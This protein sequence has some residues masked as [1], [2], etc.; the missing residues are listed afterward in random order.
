MAHV[1]LTLFDLPKTNGE[2]NK[3]DPLDLPIHDWYRFVLSFPPHLVREYIKKFGLNDQSLVLDPFCGTGTTVVECKKNGIPAIG[4]EALPMPHFASMVKTDWQIDPEDL[5]HHA[6]RIA[7]KAVANLRENGIQDNPAPGNSCDHNGLRVLPS[8]SQRLLLK[9]SIS[10]IPLHKTLVLLDAI[11]S[12]SETRFRN[13]ELLALAKALVTTIGNLRFGPEVG[14]GTIKQDAPVIGPWLA[15]VETMARDLATVS[16]RLKT[17]VEVHQ[18]DSRNVH[19]ILQSKQ[20][21]GVFTSPPYPNEKDYTRTTRLETVL[22][23]FVRNLSELRSLKK[24]L[25]RSNT[26]SVY[27]EDKDDKW[28]S[29]HTEIYRIATEIE[30]RRIEQGKTSGFERLYHRV[31][32]LYFGGIAQHLASLRSIL[33]PGAFLGYVVGD[34]ASYLRVMIRTGQLIAQIADSLGYKVESIDLFRTR[35]ATATGEQLREEVVVL[36]W[37]G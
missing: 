13:H 26:R 35:L 2:A 23:G 36:R 28:V 30:R 18:G 25:I 1:N 37:P 31:T 34:Q 11:R 32:T 17:R 20:I 29:E 14:L 4:I 27:K 9:N 10:P 5:R 12:D 8:E 15:N 6:N 16:N 22:L 33:R 19:L 3:I 21:D 24:N 7:E